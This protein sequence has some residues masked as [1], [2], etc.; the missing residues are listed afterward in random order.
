MDNALKFIIKPY[1]KSNYFKLIN[2]YIKANFYVFEDNNKFKKIFK[3]LLF[4]LLLGNNNVISNSF[5]L[6]IELINK[7]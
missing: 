2:L 5:K 4:I 7:S 6:L 3:G 1:I